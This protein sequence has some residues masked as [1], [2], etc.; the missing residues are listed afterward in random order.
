MRVFLVT[1]FLILLFRNLTEA[2]IPNGKVSRIAKG[3]IRMISFVW[4]ISAGIAVLQSQTIAERIE[5]M[6]VVDETSNISMPEESLWLQKE[7]ETVLMDTATEALKSENMQI[8]NL[9]VQLKDNNVINA[10]EVELQSKALTESLVEIQIQDITIQDP[11]KSET[12][13][14]RSMLSHI[15][16]LEESM[17][18]VHISE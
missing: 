11:A 7:Y 9:N 15:W 5:N 10:V 2:L 17:I 8:R 13:D 3:V 4:I 14:Y 6:M 12:E 18:L 1:M 16:G